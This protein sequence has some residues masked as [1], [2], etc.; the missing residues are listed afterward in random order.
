[1]EIQKNTHIFSVVFIVVGSFFA[2]NLFVGAVID[3]FNQMNEDE[4]SFL[5]SDTQKEWIRVRKMMGRAQ[6]LPIPKCPKHT[7]GRIS[8]TIIQHPR[9]ELV[10]AFAV[11]L[12]TLVMALR[13][14]GQTKDMEDFLETANL[15]FWFIFLLEA[16]MKLT[17][18][19]RN[20]F[21]TGWNLFDLA[22]VV[23]SSISIGL[24][25]VPSANSDL[26]PVANAARAFR[27]SSWCSRRSSL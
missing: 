24:S 20:Y 27:K 9:F 15:F 11:A 25:L 6:L 21:Q 23:G 14:F 26:A 2:M 16:I 4:S 3:N 5:V 12:N 13:H 22:V 8:Y 1:M 18:L 10:V 19:K 7:F 17:V